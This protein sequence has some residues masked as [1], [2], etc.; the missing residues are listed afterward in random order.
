MLHS[1]I[2]WLKAEG[3]ITSHQT[4]WEDSYIHCKVKIM[5]SFRSHMGLFKLFWRFRTIY[6]AVEHTDS[7]RCSPGR[8]DTPVGFPGRA[9]LRSGPAG[10][11]SF[12]GNPTRP[13]ELPPP[14]REQ[15][16][17]IRIVNNKAKRP[18]GVLRNTA[19][20]G[21]AD[22]TLKFGILANVLK[23]NP[24]RNQSWPRLEER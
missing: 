6:L 19:F 17:K 15:N 3:S 2:C 23:H 5:I 9:P 10:C 18:D 16:T 22:A 21:K 20:T 12:Y 24:N 13:R 8:L 4:W 14:S 1:W 7:E 11:T